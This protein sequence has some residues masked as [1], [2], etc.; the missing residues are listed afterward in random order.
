[1]RGLN[2]VLWGKV[3]LAENQ[4]RASEWLVDLTLNGLL[5]SAT[6]QPGPPAK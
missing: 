4:F 1:M 3:E 2:Q 6:H 5:G